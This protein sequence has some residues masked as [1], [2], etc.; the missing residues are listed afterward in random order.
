MIFQAI[1][2]EG[3]HAAHAETGIEFRIERLRR[4]RHEL[5]GE[6]SVSAGTLTS[7]RAIDGI[8]SAGTFNFSS[9]RARQERAKLLAERARTN[10]KLDWHGLLEE[11]CQRVLSAERTGKTCGG[12]A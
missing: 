12:L 2:G 10:G 1:D 4:E 3:Y 8:L 5:V 7:T 9:P 11:M 6:L